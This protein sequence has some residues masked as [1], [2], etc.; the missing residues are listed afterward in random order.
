MRNLGARSTRWDE[1][2]VRS[3]HAD[4]LSPVAGEPITLRRGSKP[5]LA[6][7]VRKGWKTD[8]ASI[9]NSPVSERE[10]LVVYDYGM[11]GVWGFARAQSETEILQTLPELMVIHDR[12]AWMTQ[13]Q[14]RNVRAV[15]SFTVGDGSSYPE[16][17]QALLTERRA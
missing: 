16:W 10:F 3:W 2:A 12:P 7:N 1:R 9:S 6:V 5:T 11:G 13:E 14:E 4:I 8:A 15:S 17:L